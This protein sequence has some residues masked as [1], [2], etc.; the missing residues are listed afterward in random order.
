VAHVITD[1]GRSGGAEQQLVE[2]L[3]AFADA[4]LSHSVICLRPHDAYDPNSLRSE[5]APGSRVVSLYRPDEPPGNRLRTVLRMHRAISE[6]RPDL[7]H[8]SLAEASVPAR[9]VGAA[10][11]IPV[12]ESLVNISHEPVRQVDNPGVARWKLRAHTALDRL[13]MRRVARFHALS[14]T[15]AA[16]WRDVVGI[17]EDKIEVVP[18][19][20]NLQRLDRA[21]LPEAGRATLLG[22]LGVPADAFVVLNVGRQE[23]QK[24][25]R[26][27]IEAMSA[28]LDA[29]PSAV[30]L[31]AG[32][33]GS[34]TAALAGRIEQ[35]GLGGRVTMLGTRDDV[36]RL[37]GLASV[38][39]LPSLFEG[40]SNALLEAMGSGLPCVAVDAGPMNEVIRGGS[41]GLLVPA[42]DPAAIAA[43]VVRLAGDP[44]LRRVLGGD[45]R[46][47]IEADYTSE[48]AVRGLER[49]YADV[50]GLEGS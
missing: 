10:R 43:A 13:T 19:G 41:S 38:F 49:I 25:Q 37:L 6:L 20:V 36:P 9:I 35:L 33:P 39:V 46:A 12:V 23:P 4:R 42:R 28:I 1:L 45:A 7:I 5:L 48:R 11:G 2:N 22:E 27:L 47:R 15:V 14:N 31:I 16:S 8:C 50:L 40:I 34:S 44:Q 32:R 17:P 18:R 30:L 3:R 24:G 21:R 26:Y 29:V